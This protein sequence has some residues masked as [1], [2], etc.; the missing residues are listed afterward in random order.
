MVPSPHPPLPTH[1]RWQ[2]LLIELAEL[3]L[4]LILLLAHAAGLDTTLVGL[5]IE[6]PCE[7]GIAERPV[8]VLCC[9]VPDVLE[10]PGKG[11]GGV[12]GGEESASD[13]CA[14]N[15]G[16]EEREAALQDQAGG[17][18][19]G[20]GTSLADLSALLGLDLVRFH[21]LRGQLLLVLLDF[22]LEFV[23]QCRGHVPPAFLDLGPQIFA[24]CLL[25]LES[26][27]HLRAPSVFSISQFPSKFPFFC[28]Q[29]PL[30]P[31]KTTRNL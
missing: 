21:L 1:T 12:G 8:L 15:G 22:C 9:L 19:E 16:G 5:V 14:L 17:E 28:E 18:L 26:R 24:L 13:V 2:H 29:S 23:C 11:G 10:A 27:V 3:Q 20:K 4:R 7:T 30:A 31:Q 6:L 25:R